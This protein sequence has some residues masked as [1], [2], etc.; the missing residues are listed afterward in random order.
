MPYLDRVMNNILESIN[1]FTPSCMDF[2]KR[3]KS[4]FSFFTYFISM[5]YHKH[6]EEERK[7]IF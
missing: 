5:I 1:E 7:A 6:N 4:V 2:S 3:Q